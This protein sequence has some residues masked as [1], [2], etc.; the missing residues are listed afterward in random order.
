MSPASGVHCLTLSGLVNIY[1]VEHEA[2]WALIDAGFPWSFQTILKAARERFSDA[3]PTGIL[4]TH[5]HVDHAGS[6]LALATY[7]DVNVYASESELPFLDG[8][9]NYPPGDHRVGGPHGLFARIPGLARTRGFNLG[10]RIL[11]LPNPSPKGKGLSLSPSPS[12]GEGAGGR[13]ILPGWQVIPLPGHTPGQVGFWRESDRTLLAGDAITT[14]ELNSWTRLLKGEGHIGMPPAGFT[15]DWFAVRKSVQKI[16]ELAPEWLGAGHGQPLWGAELHQKLDSFLEYA[17][18]ARKGRY[19]ARPVRQLPDGTLDIPPVPPDPVEKAAGVLIVGAVL[20]LG[21]WWFTRQRK[22]MRAADN[23]ELAALKDADQKERQGWEKLT[24]AQKE[25]LTKRDRV[26]LARVKEILKEGSI[27]TVTD[28]SNAGL[29]FQHGVTP[30]EYLVAHD[31]A[32][33]AWLLGDISSLTALSEDRFLVNIKRKQRFGSQFTVKR[34]DEYFPAPAEEQGP[35]VVTET[36]RLDYLL[37]TLASAKRVG[38]K[39]VMSK[40]TTTAWMNRLEKRLD[41]KWQAQQAK[42]PEAKELEKLA[43]RPNGKAILRVL[44]LYR[45]DN[46]KAPSDYRN[47]AS[48]LLTAT[49]ASGLA[50]AHEL[51]VIAAVRGERPARRIAAMAWDRFLAK[52]GQKPRY[53]TLPGQTNTDAVSPAVL[54]LLDCGKDT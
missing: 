37:P 40:E 11:P 5:G 13:G 10:E 23:A 49:G 20:S 47:A 43:A 46:L 31:L 30:E 32:F 21:V 34:G 41:P 33:C 16:G 22:R 50:L 4:L 26:R 45:A 29:V 7:W 53:G 28:F 6:A 54:R 14:R 44:A 9:C 48:V 24:T 52:I 36:L 27:S 12:S 1:F 25:E 42:R 39:V 15:C 35:A 51:A 8:R 2:G 19:V 3:P 38:F 17:T 18:I